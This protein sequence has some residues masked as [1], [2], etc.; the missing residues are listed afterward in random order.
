MCPWFACCRAVGAL[1]AVVLVASCALAKDEESPLAQNLKAER[2]YVRYVLPDE[3]T[4]CLAKHSSYGTGEDFKFTGATSITIDGERVKPKEVRE[5]MVGQLRF[6]DDKQT[7]TAVRIEGPIFHGKFVEYNDLLGTVLIAVILP[8]NSKELE[9]K[10]PAQVEVRLAGMKA[11]LAEVKPGAI[12]LF[13][14]STDRTKV[15]KIEARERK[16][17][18]Q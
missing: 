1:T 15:L 10:V 11:T 5:G 18:G 4:I 16:T 6:G 2:W 12:L 14:L 17:Y 9:Y 7:L 8:E 3:G 13:Q